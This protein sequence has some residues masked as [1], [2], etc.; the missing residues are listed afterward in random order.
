M[1]RRF[2]LGSILGTL[3]SPIATWAVTRSG[4]ITRG[5]MFFLPLDAVPPPPGPGDPPPGGGDPPT[6]PDPGEI[7]LP[8]PP[9]RTTTADKLNLQTILDATDTLVL[10][11][12]KDYKTGGLSSLTVTDGQSIIAGYNTVVPV[13][14]IPGGNNNILLEWVNCGNSGLGSAPGY[15]VNFTGGGGQN[16]DCE[17]IVGTLERADS[18]KI[19]VSSGSQINRLHAAYI[20]AVKVDCGSSGYV[21]DSVFSAL[22]HG[23]GQKA[24]QWIGNTTTVCSGNTFLG[25]WGLTPGYTELFVNHGDM[26]FFLQNN[27]S[28]NFSGDM[29]EFNTTKSSKHT[30]TNI[31]GEPLIVTHTGTTGV[32]GSSFGGEPEPGLEYSPVYTKLCY[33]EFKV[34]AIGASAP[35]IILGLTTIAGQTVKSTIFNALKNTY[36]GSTPVASE[37]SFGY[38]NNGSLWI[39][40]TETPAWGPT[41]T[42]A[43]YIG[44][45]YDGDTLTAY[46]NGTLV[47]TIASAINLDLY[48]CAA[49]FDIN[50]QVQMHT[51]TTGN[52]AWRQQHKPSAAIAWGNGLDMNHGFTFRNTDA[53]SNIWMMGCSG[54]HSFT[55]NCGAEYQFENLKVVNS[56]KHWPEGGSREPQDDIV[57]KNVKNTVV[58]QG[59]SSTD[60][61]Y[62]NDPGTLARIRIFDAVGSETATIKTP[63]ST[64]LK[65]TLSA[66]ELALLQEAFTP[67]TLATSPTKPTL[68]TINDALGASWETLI[69]G[70]AD[71]TATIQAKLDADGIAMLDK[72]VYVLDS[73]LTVGDKTR[74]E[75]VIGAHKDSV[76]LVARGSHPIFIG[77]TDAAT[78]VPHKTIVL[79]HVTLYGGTY[80]LRFDRSVVGRSF[81]DWCVFK[82]VKFLKQTVASIS[83]LNVFSLDN[84]R[85][86][87][88]DF[89]EVPVCFDGVGNI[90]ANRPYCDKF[91]VIDCQFQTIAD[92]VFLWNVASGRSGGGHLWKNCYAK[93]VSGALY[94]STGGVGV[95]WANCVFENVSGNPSMWVT[96]NSQG[97]T[98]QWFQ[99]ACKWMGTGPTVV[100]GTDIVECGVVFIDTEFAQ[101][102]GN[103]VATTGNQTL[104]TWNCTRTGTVGVPVPTRSTIINSA[105]GAIDVG[106]AMHFDDATF[107]THVAGPAAPYNMVL[108]R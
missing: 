58:L 43:D 68:R 103:I 33:L 54:G 97:Y 71:S 83:L 78:D 63:T 107:K 76:Y 56:F 47:G 95:C 32:W 23:H 34:N 45:E 98:R 20:G 15:D 80:A 61:G 104:F 108:A 77:R 64:S 57:F 65:S 91:F 6:P 14:N 84:N 48:P 18:P 22:L 3:L 46:K 4:T 100:A 41:Y 92:K 87:R 2:L 69:S 89:K 36:P 52:T 13:I 81:Y 11:S 29:A 1:K 105:L 70:L 35:S 55:A 74:V 75:G 49:T 37:T 40:G 17:I 82:D 30:H 8:N 24:Q 85:I 106:F 12:N 96:N 90:D 16:N 10:E 60:I 25:Y 62:Y 19:K 102:G 101:T 28:W 94:H 21:R 66:G 72:G 42:T 86:Y 39:A 93:D 53:T 99:V 67:A 26:W 51:M 9:A 79:E 31:G 88:C 44:F 50:N 59:Y 38:A 73:P 5:T 7:V 27:E